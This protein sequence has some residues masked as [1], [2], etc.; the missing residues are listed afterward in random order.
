ME[1]TDLNKELYAALS[2]TYWQCQHIYCVLTKDNLE[3]K[4]KQTSNSM[5][6]INITKHIQKQCCGRVN[7]Y[8]FSDPLVKYK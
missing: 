8:D 7:M 2:A 1:D 4:K 6:I 3:S 5:S